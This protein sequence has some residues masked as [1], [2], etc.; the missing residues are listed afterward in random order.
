M[1]PELLFI[2]G[3][4][5]PERAPAAIAPTAQRLRPFGKATIFGRRFELGEYPGVVL[6]DNSADAGEQ[7]RGELYFLPEGAEGAEVLTR[8]DAYEDFR[9]GDPSGSLFVRQRTRATL[10]DGTQRECWVYT[11]NQRL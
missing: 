4:L 8:L 11:Y 1:M 10:E 5:H 2:Y 3:T 7:V 9:P 6:S